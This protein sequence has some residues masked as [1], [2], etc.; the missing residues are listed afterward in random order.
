VAEFGSPHLSQNFRAETL[1]DNHHVADEESR[2]PPDE[3]GSVGIK[4]DD[5][6]WATGCPEEVEMA[7]PVDSSEQLMSPSGTD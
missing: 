7:G 1:E 5:F 4:L 2:Q 3:A 6:P